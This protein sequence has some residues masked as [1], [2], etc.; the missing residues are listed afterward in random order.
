M[1]QTV[2]QK[3]VVRKVIDRNKERRVTFA[4]NRLQVYKNRKHKGHSA[5][6]DEKIN[7]RRLEEKLWDDGVNVRPLYPHWTPEEWRK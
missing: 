4:R 2:K 3:K 6:L 7:I 5:T 1:Y